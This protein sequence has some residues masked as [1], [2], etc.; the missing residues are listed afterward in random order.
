MRET[1][2]LFSRGHRSLVAGLRRLRANTW[3]I[4]QTA[5]AATI[6]YFLATFFLGI[7]QVFYAPIAAIVCLSVTLGQPAVRAILVSIGIAIGLAVADLIA[8]VIGVGTV[9]VGIVVALAMAAA[10]LLSERPMLVNQAAISAILVVVL[11]PPQQTGFSP[12]RFLDALVGGGVALVVN[13]LFPADPERMVQRAVHPIFTEL[14]LTLEEAAAALRDVDLNRA[15]RALSQARGIDEQVSSF[16]DI[17][18]AGQETARYSPI[19]RRELRHLQLYSSTAEQLDLTVRDVRS[20][21][22]A[23]TSAVQHSSSASAPLSEAMFKL[24]RAFLSLADYLEESGDPE[25][26]RQLAL[27]AACKAG[28]A[29]K[30]YRADLP[31]IMIAG[32]IRTTTV[33]LLESTG[34]ERASALQ[35]LE[36]AAGGALEIY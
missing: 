6:A 26:T 22:R 5:L 13:Y 11:Q 3:P 27:D 10:V 23:T 30:E 12:D 8:L 17:L 25:D 34:M 33:D 21:A 2:R 15:E 28:A 31:T 9:Q 35:M 29:L 24:A 32:Q 19:K 16:R 1:R 14:V 18:D 7:H 36:E 20:I 4:L